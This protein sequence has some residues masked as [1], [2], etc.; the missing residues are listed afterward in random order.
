MG[1][2][3]V[4]FNG[5][6]LNSSDAVAGW[7]NYNVGGGAPT[8]EPANAY[9]QDTPGSS[10]GAVGKKIVSTSARQGVDYYNATSV[11]YTANNYLWFAK[12]YVADGFNVNA[13]WGVELAIGSGDDTSKHQYNVAGSGANNDNYLQYPAQGGYIITAIDPTIDGWAE[14]ADSGGAFDQTNVRYYAVGAQFISGNAKSENVAMD[15]IDYGTGLYLLGGDGVDTDGTFVDFIAI[16]QDIKSNRWGVVTGSGSSLTVR[17]ILQIGSSTAVGFTDT[18]SIV[19]FADGYHSTGSVGI[20]AYCSNAATT[21]TIDSLLIGNG[22]N[23]LGITDTRP[24]FEVLGT[25][26]TFNSAATLRNFREVIFTSVCEVENA[27]IECITLTQGGAHIFNTTIKTGANA[28]LSLIANPTLGST[29]GIHDIDFIQVGEGHTMSFSTPGSYTFNNITF[30]GYGADTTNNAAIHV[31]ATTGIFNFF[32]NGGDTPTYRTSGA[33]VNIFNSV[34]VSV[35][36]KNVAGTP[37]ENARVLIEADTGGDLAVGTD[38]LTGLTNASGVAENTTFN[39][40][41]NQPIKGWVRKSSGSPYYKQ[42][43]IAGTIINTG[44]TTTILMISDE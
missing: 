23:Y 33:T 15:A 8:S 34:T 4:G 22:K 9:Q 17:G 30:T 25:T 19:N 13:T 38:I 40:T 21:I 16:D 24:N 37:I 31:S 11:N 41:N 27:D 1:V 44:L 6:R 43:I 20:K 26:G 36:V 32:V 12:V 14:V 5:T 35:I 28:S 2:V 18:T 3:L 29:T 10:V 7:G 39:F 42:S